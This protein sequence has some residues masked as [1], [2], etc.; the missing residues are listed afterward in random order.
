M[1][2]KK[3]FKSKL[4]TVMGVFRYYSCLMKPIVRRQLKNPKTIPV[5]INNFNQL[6][7]LKQ[8]IEKLQ[9]YSIENIVILDNNSTFPPLLKYYE[10]VKNDVKVIRLSRNKGHLAF[11]KTK[12]VFKKYS[13]GF[14]VVTDADIVP[15]DICPEDLVEKLTKLSLKYKSYTKIGV[16]LKINDIPDH[17]VNKDK[18][19][20]WEKQYWQIEKSKMV[21]EAAVDTTFALYRP[22]YIYSKQNFYKALR[23]KKPY[24]AKHGGWYI[25]HENLTE[26][27]LYYS[28]TANSS[29]SWNTDKQN[30]PT[31]SMYNF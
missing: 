27:Q 3:T 12:T 16:S 25:N 22:N 18:V 24:Q 21:Y 11:W 7:Y 14:Y 23:T 19:L 1:G 31:N 20:N 15:I 30:N 17:Y 13:T 2:F 6:F 10:V 28:K 26:E 8:L 29:S 5:I 9:S 4:K